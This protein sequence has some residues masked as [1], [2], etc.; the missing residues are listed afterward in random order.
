MIC[1]T[2]FKMSIV[3]YIVKIVYRYICDLWLVPHPTI[4]V[5]HLRIHGMYVY[6]H[7]YVYVCMYVCMHV[8]V[9]AYMHVHMNLFMYVCRYV[10]TCRCTFL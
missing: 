1:I 8:F 6:M 10:C 9:Y 4:F 3:L 2:V 5:T 7:I